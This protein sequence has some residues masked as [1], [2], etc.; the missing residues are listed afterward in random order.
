MDKLAR[1]VSLFACGALLL[2]SGAVALLAQ[3][4]PP[5]LRVTRLGTSS[6]TLVVTRGE[7]V[8]LTIIAYD[9]SGGVVETPIRVTG[10]RDGV[11]I[12]DGRVFGLAAGE[13]EIFASV[14]LPADAGR[15][16]V[17]LTIPVTVDWPAI[18]RVEITS[19]HARLFTGT[20]ALHTVTAFHADGTT[21]PGASVRWT[22][23]ETPVATVDRHGYVTGVSVGSVTISASVEGV[24]EDVAYAVAAFPA[25]SLEIVGGLEEV[26]TGDVQD[27]ELRAAGPDGEI[28]SDIPVTWTLA[29]RPAEGIVAPSAPGQ[30]E[31]GRMVAD[32]PG[33]YTVMAS[34][35]GLSATRRFTVTQRDVVQRVNVVGQGRQTTHYTSDFWIFEGLDSRDYALTGARQAQ[36]HAFVWDVTNPANIIKTDSVRVD[37]RSL[38][39]V[40]TSP[41]GRYGVI[42]REGASN[43]RNGL[44][45]LD[46]AD[47]A[48]PSIAS[49]YD[50]GVTGGVHNVFALN[51]YLF[52]LSGGDKYI[53]LDMRD[54]YD[55][56]YVSEYD[57]PDSRVHD[58]WVADG[59]AYSAEW[60]TGVVMV[61]VG[62]GRWGGTIESPKLITTY[63]LP[64]GSTHAVFPYTSEST[65]KQLLFVG[66][67]ITNRRGK[68]WQGNGPDVR[69]AFDPETGRGG[70]PRVTSGY[71]QIL[72]LSDPEKPEM[73]ARYEV[74]EYGT[75]NIW[76]EDDILYQAYYEGGMRLVDVSGELMGNLYTQG[77]EIA[78][79]KANDP[80][81]WIANAPAAW[82]VIPYKGH[83]FFSDIS[84]GLWAVKL[85]PKGRPVS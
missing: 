64:T 9:A 13:Y 75:H 45:I 36:S 18:S 17:Q 81:G 44:V 85:E 30:L 34:A 39:D 15:A 47:P 41:D 70:Y 10:P 55:P 84:S 51:D 62:N 23:G 71:I 72:D 77:R 11:R 37:A 73:I 74:T 52:A 8:P 49:V 66:D 61:D 54:I 50:E 68:A 40:K 59:I 42:S 3:D 21:R 22:S 83:V 27:F 38:N 5:A 14:T 43:R 20:T 82:S 2:T 35:G 76:V 33:T 31:E 26:R 28:V 53:I 7:S 63:P 25:A 80:Q 60:E 57:H 19:T 67:E 16:P 32:V 6:T 79:H 4:T 46:L 65:G 78:V 1:V 56:T 58:V 24:S 12:E 69:M 48:H 29:F